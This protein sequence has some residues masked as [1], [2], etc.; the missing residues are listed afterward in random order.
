MIDKPVFDIK[1]KL[2]K[3]YHYD[4]EYYV[5]QKNN[6]FKQVESKGYIYT[7]EVSVV[8]LEIY[9]EL[10]IEKPIILELKILRIK[11]L[12]NAAA[13]ITGEDGSGL[14]IV[15]KDEKYKE[16]MEKYLNGG[17]PIWELEEKILPT[18]F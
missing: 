3:S 16:R 9:G 4:N 7:D 12:T 17:E 11:E 13:L 6:V 15:F 1:G 8:Q 14:E 18:I 5:I 2:T 10:L